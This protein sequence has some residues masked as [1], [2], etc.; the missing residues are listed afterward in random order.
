MQRGSGFLQWHFRE[1][2]RQLT[3]SVGGGDDDRRLVASYL[4]GG[5][6]KTG[7]NTGQQKRI[8][9]IRQRG[10]KTRREPV[11]HEIGAPQLRGRLFI[12]TSQRARKY[13]AFPEKRPAK[14]REKK[15]RPPEEHS[16]STSSGV[17]RTDKQPQKK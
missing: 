4:S 17:R 14:V 15:L 6:N 12:C 3:G 9:Y 11:F 7:D 10:W 5:P 8:I 2:D 1:S 16:E 13:F